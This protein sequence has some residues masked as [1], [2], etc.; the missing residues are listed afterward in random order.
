MGLIVAVHLGYLVAVVVALVLLGRLLPPG[1]P[2]RYPGPVATLACLLLA[3]GLYVG[4]HALVP[5]FAPLALA[6]HWAVP[7]PASFAWVQAAG[8]LAPVVA[9]WIAV[10]AFAAVRFRKKD[11][12]GPKA[13]P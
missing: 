10:F 6:A 12:R 8:V 1:T 4:P 3:P 7:S 11:R 9:C 2:S 5:T 13:A